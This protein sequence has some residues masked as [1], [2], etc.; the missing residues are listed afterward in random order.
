MQRLEILE[1]Y[2]KDSQSR[3]SARKT[4]T[5]TSGTR[6]AAG[7]LATGHHHHFPSDKYLDR[8]SFCRRVGRGWIEMTSPHTLP[9]KSNREMRGSSYILKGIRCSRGAK[10]AGV[11]AHTNADML[12]VFGH[13][14]H[15]LRV[16]P[17]PSSGTAQRRLARTRLEVTAA[18]GIMLNTDLYDGSNSLSSALLLAA[19]IPSLSLSPTLSK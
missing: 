3:A 12:P 17:S 11:S 8:S 18:T 14:N 10:T 15:V 7:E 5:P 19:D 9:C 6:G 2:G 4:L 1:S 13:R 16:L